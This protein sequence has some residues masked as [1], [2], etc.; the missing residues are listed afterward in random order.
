MSAFFRID[1]YL[2]TLNA[3]NTF[4]H[5]T[6]CIR[7]L[8]Y[9]IS[10]ITVLFIMVISFDAFKEII[11]LLGHDF[12]VFDYL[13]RVHH[14]KFRDVWYFIFQTFGSLFSTYFHV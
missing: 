6:I 11:S 1:H 12:F 3:A 4:R 8:L 10:F 7:C 14:F 5:V 13:L 9:N 2:L